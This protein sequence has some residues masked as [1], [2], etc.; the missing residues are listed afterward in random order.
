MSRFFFFFFHITIRVQSTLKLDTLL[1]SLMN[2]CSLT[3]VGISVLLQ[4]LFLRVFN[5]QNQ[6]QF[7]LFSCIL[8]T[9]FETVRF[10]YYYYHL[11]IFSSNKKKTIIYSSLSL[12]VSGDPGQKKALNERPYEICRLLYCTNYRDVS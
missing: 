10:H 2:V 11:C 6:I 8:E 12:C 4:T 1:I 3:E 9:N 7:I 5:R